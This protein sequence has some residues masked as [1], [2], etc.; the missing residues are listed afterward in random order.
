MG[1]MTSLKNT[2]LIEI[3]YLRHPAENYT[4]RPDTDM[5]TNKEKAEKIRDLIKR[6]DLSKSAYQ[7]L[8]NLKVKLKEKNRVYLIDLLMMSKSCMMEKINSLLKLPGIDLFEGFYERLQAIESLDADGYLLNED[9]WHFD[10]VD[11]NTQ[12]VNQHTA[13]EYIFTSIYLVELLEYWYRKDVLPYS[14]HYQGAFFTHL[15]FGL[16]FIKNANGPI[17]IFSYW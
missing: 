6:T 7:S 1:D 16:D 4:N 9:K 10:F 17:H 12:K 8:L 14:R 13:G 2:Q 5:A 15:Q 3:G 11:L